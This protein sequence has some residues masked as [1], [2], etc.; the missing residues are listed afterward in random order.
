MLAIRNIMQIASPLLMTKFWDVL[1]C[2]FYNFFKELWWVPH[3]TE[4]VK[5][6]VDFERGSLLSRITNETVFNVKLIKAVNSCLENCQKQLNCNSDVIC[7]ICWRYTIFE[8]FKSLSI[9]IIEETQAI[10]RFVRKTMVEWQDISAI[11]G[12]VGIVLYIGVALSLTVTDISIHNHYG[13]QQQG[14]NKLCGTILSWWYLAH[15]IDQSQRNFIGTL[16]V[17]L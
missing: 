9:F 11:V 7:T 10:V 1:T 6:N 14:H 2:F 17:K 4:P 3:N 15:V 5:I 12:I 8:C 16:S 13:S